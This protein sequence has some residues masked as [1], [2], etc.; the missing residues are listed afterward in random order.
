MART[1]LLRN[2]ENA[3]S[4]GRAS[5]AIHATADAHARTDAPASAS[6]RGLATAPPPAPTFDREARVRDNSGRHRIV[7]PIT[8]EAKVREVFTPEER[9]AV[10]RA[11]AKERDVSGPRR[12]EQRP[13]PSPPPYPSEREPRLSSAAKRWLVAFALLL[14]FSGMLYATYR[15]VNNMRSSQPGQ[16]QPGQQGGTA[17]NTTQ[18]GD[19]FLTT[20]DADLRLGPGASFDKV[21]LAENGSRVKLIQTNGKWGRYR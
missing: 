19:I 8:G 10:E 5:T 14:A 21:G 13:E 9:G 1:R 4:N 15:Y 18:A 2:D 12:A 11:R 7:V 6:S 16:Q 17:R 3:S 20:T